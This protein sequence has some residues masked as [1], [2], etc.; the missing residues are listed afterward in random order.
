MDRHDGGNM[1]FLKQK[2]RRF[3]WLLLFMSMLSAPSPVIAYPTP[4]DFS[5]KLLRWNISTTDPV[6]TYEVTSTSESLTAEGLGIVGDAIYFWNNAPN[7]YARFVRAVSGQVAMVTI[8]FEEIIDGG[9]HSAG[10]SQFDQTSANGPEHCEV[11]VG[12]DSSVSYT[13]LGKTTLHEL[14]HCLGLGHSLIPEAI[15]SYNLEKNHFGLDVDDEAAVARLYPADGDA[16]ALPPGCAVGQPRSKDFSQSANVL[17]W[18]VF[19]AI[20]LIFAGLCS[21]YKGNCKPQVLC[22]GRGERNVSTT[23]TPRFS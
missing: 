3:T 19:F 18:S 9:E 10:Y 11:F 22:A 4:V 13:S 20:P 23:T 15:M 2:N 21:M 16:S 7:S 6:I 17:F 8:H 12:A 5:G 1:I 14:G